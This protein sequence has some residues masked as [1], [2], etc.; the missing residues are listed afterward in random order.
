[1][2]PFESLSEIPEF[3]VLEDTLLKRASKRA[4]S[5]S[6]KGGKTTTARSREEIRITTL[7]VGLK[8]HLRKA[9]KIGKS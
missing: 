1:M 7:S 2:N 3:K 8:K 4:M 5:I 9:I 6:Y